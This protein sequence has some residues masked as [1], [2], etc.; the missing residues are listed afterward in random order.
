MI[1]TALLTTAYYQVLRQANLD[2][3]ERRAVWAAPCATASAFLAF[4]LQ[5]EWV[6]VARHCWPILPSP[7]LAR[8]IWTLF[9]RGSAMFALAVR[10]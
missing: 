5:C 6:A 3:S 7:I 8:P 2:N 9:S 1:T 4:F 10:L